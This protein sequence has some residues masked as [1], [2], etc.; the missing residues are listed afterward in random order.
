MSELVLTSVDGEVGVLTVNNPPV[1]ALSPGFPKEYWPASSTSKDEFREGDRADRRRPHLHRRRRHQASSARSPRAATADAGRAS[2]RAGPDRRTARSR[3]IAAIHGTA[4]G[5]GLETAMACHYRVAVPSAQ[6]G[7]PEVKLG[8]IP[9]A[10]GTQRCRGWRASRKRGDVR[11]RRSDRAPR[12]RSNAES[13][14]GS[15]KAIC[16]RARWHSP[17][18]KIGHAAAAD[19]RSARQARQCEHDQ[20]AALRRRARHRPQDEQR[21]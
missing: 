1:N 5:G 12:R 18:A 19:P 8:I 14:T 9:G 20:R 16:W 2:R 17:R 15:S 13:S 3:S 7:Q 21:N 6:V 11:R 10:G 4:F